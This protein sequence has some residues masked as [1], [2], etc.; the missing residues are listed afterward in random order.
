MSAHSEFEVFK[1]IV[2]D[3]AIEVMDGLIVKEI[4]TK[5]LRHNMAVLENVGA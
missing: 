2:R 5:M 3:I 4:P 1:P